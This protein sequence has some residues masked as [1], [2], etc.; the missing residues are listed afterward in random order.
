MMSR[1][2]VVALVAAFAL[3][4][5]GCGADTPAP[6]YPSPQDPAL[7]DTDLWQ[8]VG[9]EDA[10]DEDDVPVDEEP[11]EDFVPEGEEG[12]EAAPAEAPAEAAEAGAEGAAA[13][14]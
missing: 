8:H 3:A 12:G 9:A 10:D 14:E 4:L 7:E 2:T 11:F 6:A 1:T 13:A 5:V